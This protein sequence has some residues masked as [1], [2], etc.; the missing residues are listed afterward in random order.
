[1]RVEYRFRC[2]ELALDLSFDAFTPPID[3]GERFDLG[4]D[5]RQKHVQA[6]VRVDLPLS[7][8]LQHALFLSRATS[9]P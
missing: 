2:P 4:D 3:F 9:A 5:M 6:G 8:A 7:E 1:M